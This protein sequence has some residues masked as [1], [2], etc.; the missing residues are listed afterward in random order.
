LIVGG[1]RT[2]RVAGSEGV[3]KPRISSRDLMRASR[4]LCNAAAAVKVIG[5]SIIA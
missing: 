3:K 4:L 1:A 5:P 2:L